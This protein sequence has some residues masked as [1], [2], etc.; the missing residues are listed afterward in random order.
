MNENIIFFFSGTGN[1]F[2]ITLRLAK[3]IENTDILNIPSIRNI[4]SLVNYKRI[5]LIFPVY[6]FTMPNIVESFILKMPQNNNAYYF[7]LVTMGA[8][9]F[10]AMYRTYETFAKA[11]I[12]LNYIT[13]IYMPENYIIF[14]KVP[15]DKLIKTHLDNSKKRIR[16][17]S[18]ELI[19]MK[20]K[21][22]NKTMFYNLMKKVSIKEKQKWRLA[23]KN[24]VVN[25]SC[26][27]CQKCIKICP[28][29]NIEL[30]EDK[31]VFNERC[32]C[33]LACIHSCP[34]EAINYGIKTINKKRYIN[35]NIDI[36]EIK[37]YS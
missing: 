35:P 10:G 21:L 3:E 37:K 36:E 4:P 30:A 16:N 24:F 11:G 2:D 29:E 8:F 9:D 17:I 22:P 19:C 13:N 15:S 31:I 28:V 32:E 6:G 7:S 34:K 18:S 27:K 1:S 12:R 23:A 33:C 5:G 25:E 20:N 26:I 14:S